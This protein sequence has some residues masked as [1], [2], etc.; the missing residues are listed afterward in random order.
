MLYDK[1]GVQ[2]DDTRFVVNG[3][4]YPVNSIASVTAIQGVEGSWIDVFKL[5]IG[6]GVAGAILPIFLGQNLGNTIGGI[7]ILAGIY[8]AWKFKPKQIYYVQISTS[9][10]DQ[11]AYASYDPN[12]IQEIVDAINQAIINRG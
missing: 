4:T 9:G 5:L 2:V 11:R 7:V 8:L 10:G 3:T 6:V 1:N 12:E